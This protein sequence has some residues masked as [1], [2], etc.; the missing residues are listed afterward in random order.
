MKIVDAVWEK[1][2]L[3]VNTVEVTFESGD[4]LKEI[5]DLLKE[6]KEE[7]IVLKVPTYLTEIIPIVQ[8]NGYRYIEDMIY[9]V[10]YLQDIVRNPI[11]QRMYD[12]VE[13]E[14]MNVA[15]MEV[16]YKEIRSGIF[17]SD[18][19]YLDSYF[20]HQIAKERYINWIKD[21]YEKGTEF[22]KYLYKENTIGF[23]AIKEVEAGHYT[24]FIGGIYK[25]YRKG[26]LGAVVKVP[27]AV[28]LRD[29]KRVST[30]V[31]SNNI[32][33]VKSLVMN[34]YIPESI[35]HTFTKHC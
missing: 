34:G 9:F 4:S 27:E 3:G 23:F 13:I 10:N 28:R 1:R 2:N 31:S 6:L 24:S 15:D 5:E 17:D 14:T 33:Q 32:K 21:E 20:S 22:L 30:S 25:E 18:R 26:G 16:L 29:G 19:I 7:Y 8:D 11:Q 12:A 35:S